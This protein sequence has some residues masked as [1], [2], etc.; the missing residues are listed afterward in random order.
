MRK[1]ATFQCHTRADIDEMS[2]EL[3]ESGALEQALERLDGWSLAEAG[4][5]IERVFTFHDFSEAFAFMTR[6]ALLAEKLDHHPDWRNVYRRVEVSLS[7]HDA[8]GVTDLDIRMAERLNR[9][10]AS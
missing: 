3:L 10:A 4:N 2:R 1:P 5:A 8:G 7:T 6:V 9:F